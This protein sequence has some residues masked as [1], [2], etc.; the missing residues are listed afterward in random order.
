M[1]AEIIHTT[2]SSHHIYFGGPFEKRIAT[3]TSETITLFG[4]VISLSRDPLV[5][6]KQL[7][8]DVQRSKDTCDLLDDISTDH[9]IRVVHLL[10][11]NKELLGQRALCGLPD[12][13]GMDIGVLKASNGYVLIAGERF[14]CGSS[15][16][17]AV[18]A[19]MEAGVT[20]VIAK[21]FGPTFE[22][23]AAYLGLLTS[24]NLDIADR[25]QQGN[26]IPL[27][28]F[29]DGKTDLMQE[30]VRRGG[31]FSYLREVNAGNI[32]ER[33]KHHER[34]LSRSMN[35]AEKRLARALQKAS[36]QAG[37]EGL[38]PVDV[39]YSYVV[40]SGLAKLAMISAYGGIKV[41][42]NRENIFLFEDHFAHSERPEVEPLTTNQR[43]FAK[44]LEIPELNYYKGKRSEGG[45]SGICHRVMLDRIDPRKTKVVVATDSHTP[46][47]GSLPILALP[48]GSTLFASAIA[49]GKIPYSVPPVLRI[50]FSGSLLR[51]SSIRDAQLELAGTVRPLQNNMIVEY[52]G[53]GIDTLSMDQ[54]VALCNMVP[55]V[56]NTPTAV[57]EPFKAG[58]R[59]LSK[60]LGISEDEARS[61]YDLPDP[62]C[63][64]AQIIH[65]DLDKVAPWIALPGSP[66]N[67]SSLRELQH[68]P[69]IDKA[70]L[71]S[72]TL[73]LQ[74][75]TE[76]AAVLLGKKIVEGTQLIVIP[77]SD[78]IRQQAES[79]G[80]LQILR[81]AGAS[82]VDESACGPCIG[83][84][85]GAVKDGE[86]AITA[87]N[88][89]FPGRMGSKKAEVYMGGAIIT[90]LASLIGHIPSMQEYNEN[91]DRIFYN[92]RTL[93]GEE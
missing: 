78:Q 40:T 1:T 45:G 57:T 76:A 63:E 12:E 15:R 16:E 60:K 19:L 25:I 48:V 49:E 87:S 64:Y 73:G 23:N 59:Y 65:Y 56:F 39:A 5:L 31:L 69:H 11:D 58:I 80:I 79:K 28:E 44:E 47:I 9:I 84:G 61:L 86:T 62:D 88:R 72:C 51:G 43:E 75:L 77:S 52:G 8:P 70:F 13:Y 74:D 68:S 38:L 29:L 85:L 53:S 17:H 20:A 7:F 10:T 6:R 32:Q 34:R 90:S 46:T 89:N 2:E 14:G 37:D 50:Q 30:I 27:Q 55:E 54:V 41:S 3:D 42:M 66:N 67:T 24:R 22:S 91:R 35:V 82:I 71:V 4:G 93:I 18:V 33:S 81:E 83:E 26:A 21:S 92:L 36:V